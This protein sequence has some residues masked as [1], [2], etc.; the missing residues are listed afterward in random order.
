MDRLKS[1]YEKFYRQFPYYGNLL[2]I[3]LETTGFQKDARIIEI[4]AIA[5]K[6]D[7]L[8]VYFDTFESLI[9]PGFALPTKITEVTGITDQDLENAPGDEKFA[10]F[11]EWLLNVNAKKCVA[12]NATFDKNKLEYNLYDVLDI[13]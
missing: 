7:G 12:H 6:F 9:N 1:V 2:I 3:D 5:I 13:I 8:D 4:G 10:E 11:V